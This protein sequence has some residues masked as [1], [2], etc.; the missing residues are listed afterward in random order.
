M[1]A[2][3]RVDIEAVSELIR[4]VVAEEVLPAF[5]QLLP[6]D[7][8]RKPSEGDPEDVVSR[9]DKAV[10]ARLGP[11]LSRLLPGSAVVGEEAAHADPSVLQALDGDGAVWIIDPIDGTRGFVR[12][13]DAF[14]VMVALVHQKRAV[15]AWIALPV[16]K[17]LF[18]AEAGAGTWSN[19]ARVRTPTPAV[20][21]L[22]RGTLY[23]RYLAQAERDALEAASAGQYRLVPGTG[24]AAIEYTDLVQGRKEFVIYHRL[25]PWD[26]VPGALIVTEAGGSALLP[27]GAPF[28]P[29]DRMGPLIAATDEGTS[30][31]VRS[32]FPSRG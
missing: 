14:G 20:G 2:G 29:A 17:Q 1:S 32:W 28:V 8:E 22:P 21:E 30:A 24:S 11:A 19:G 23:T 18:A 31:R 3:A 6:E 26:H 7:I 27:S 9:V 13:E 4:E 10:E 25:H 15:G 5:G 12:G 16:R